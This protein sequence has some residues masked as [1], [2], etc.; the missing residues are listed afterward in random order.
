MNLD[1]ALIKEAQ[2]NPYT[3]EYLNDI[4]KTTD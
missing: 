3:A 1:D 2:T 4:Y